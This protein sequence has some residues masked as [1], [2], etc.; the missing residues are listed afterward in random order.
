VGARIAGEIVRR[1]GDAGLPGTEIELRFVGSAGQSFGAFC[2][3]GMRMI[4]F[5]DAND[6]VG[7]GMHGGEIIVRPPEGASYAWHENVIMGNTVLYGATGGRLFAAGR[8]G[9]RF[10]V[11]N[12]GAMAVVEGVG[13]HGCEYM[14]GGVILVLGEVGRNFAAGMTGG[15]AF[16]FDERGCLPRRYNPELVCLVPLGDADE[17]LVCLLLREHARATSS[18]RAQELLERWGEWKGFFWKVLPFGVDG[19]IEAAIRERAFASMSERA[20]ESPSDVFA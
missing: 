3:P 1:Y 4:L 7:K 17:E 16:V 6:Y 18:P 15:L 2:V 10:A 20:L 8:A 9:E 14:T 12:S 19:R 13:D 5:G 11:R